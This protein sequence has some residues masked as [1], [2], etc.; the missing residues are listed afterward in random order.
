MELE[1]KNELE[2]KRK[3]QERL[4]KFLDRLK[5]DAQ[6]KHL[7]YR[8][9]NSPHRS[10]EKLVEDIHQ[11]LEESHFAERLQEH[12]QQTESKNWSYF[13][14]SFKA[15]DRAQERKEQLHRSITLLRKVTGI[16]LFFKVS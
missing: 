6:S 9:D 2:R 13:S 1:K 14:L 7:V 5:R 15:E 10:P 3:E 4:S 8:G 11:D 12:L 16:N